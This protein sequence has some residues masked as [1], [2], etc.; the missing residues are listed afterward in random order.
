VGAA[1]MRLGAILEWLLAAAV[2]VAAVSVGS[3]A[4]R[5]VR[6]VRAVMPVIAREARP[7]QAPAG[8]PP[9]SVAV[10]MVLLGDGREVRLGDRAADVAARLGAA[11]RVVSESIERSDAHARITRFY[12]YLG[13]QFVLVFE[14]PQPA[15]EPH[16][17]AIYLR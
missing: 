13:L 5:E 12:D 4:L 17:A 7:G 6:T 15:A 8:L 1:R 9:R 11:V 2:I 3:V 16:V 10:P 14:A